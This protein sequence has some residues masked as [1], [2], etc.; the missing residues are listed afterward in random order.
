MERLATLFDDAA[1]G[2]F[3]PVDGT[4]EV[5]P[6]PTDLALEAIL[7]FTGHAVVVT[8]LSADEVH[9]RGL[10][11]YGGIV[12]PDFQRFLA[13][14]DGEIGCHDAVLVRR[15]TGRPSLEERTDLDDHPRVVAARRR[16]R[17][18]TVLGDQRG[19]ATVGRGLGNRWEV[20]VELLDD[21]TH[22]T[23][24]GR[25]LIARAMGHVPDG[26]AVFASVAP[27]N[28]ASLRAFLACG[29]AP[30]GAEIILHPARP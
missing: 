29:F 28:A 11:A 27:G 8:D 30:I 3:P 20:S 1:E 5:L 14:P 6:A 4:I 25:E 10:D 26:Q 7:E 15:G 12:S 2:I 17:D 16:R 22:G 19:L 13:G 21:T 9:G 18:V 24:V 23:G